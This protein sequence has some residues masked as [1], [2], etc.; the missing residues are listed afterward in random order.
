M[1][2]PAVFS[3]SS[4]LLTRRRSQN[5]PRKGFCFKTGQ[6]IGLDFQK[7]RGMQTKKYLRS[8]RKAQPEF[9]VLFQQ[10][11]GFQLLTN[12]LKSAIVFP[13]F[14]N[15]IFCSSAKNSYEMSSIFA[16]L[17]RQISHSRDRQ[18]KQFPVG[19]IKLTGKEPLFLKY[20]QLPFINPAPFSSF[21][22]PSFTTVWKQRKLGRKRLQQ[23]LIKEILLTKTNSIA[24]EI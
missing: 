2:P 16:S 8:L 23:C 15:C 3:S 14:S 13:L 10:N 12:P 22:A 24:R 7:S 11:R 20:I 18:I 1:I 19:Y 17:L 5:N 9:T 6:T 21:R 4:S